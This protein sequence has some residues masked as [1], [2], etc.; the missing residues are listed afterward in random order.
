MRESDIR[1]KLVDALRPLD[2]QAVEN[3]INP[4][5]PDIE[6]IG[7]WIEIKYI[8]EWPAKDTT[9]V[10]IPHFTKQQ[11]IWIANRR[12]LG[13]LV[14]IVLR[15]CDDWFLFDNSHLDI[16]ELTREQMLSSCYQSWHRIFVPA[17]FLEAVKRNI[18]VR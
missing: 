1:K 13:G 6:F 8:R 16:D 10:R 3:P 12:R 17:E 15:V 7:G 14:L 2:A 18:N 4:G 5:T 9:P 11:R